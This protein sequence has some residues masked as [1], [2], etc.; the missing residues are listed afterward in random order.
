[1]LAAF[2]GC[3]ACTQAAFA[4][5][6]NCGARITNGYSYQTQYNRSATMA[7]ALLTP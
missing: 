5:N 7:F 2:G 1:L 3:G 6:L 4:V